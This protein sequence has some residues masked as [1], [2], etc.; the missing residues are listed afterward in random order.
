MDS[1]KIS[2]NLIRSHTPTLTTL[3]SWKV[4]RL[5][6]P[7]IHCVCV[8][9]SLFKSLILHCKTPSWTDIQGSE[10]KICRSTIWLLYYQRWHMNMLKLFSSKLQVSRGKNPQNIVF[11]LNLLYMDELNTSVKTLVRG[12]KRLR[13][14]DLAL[15]TNNKTQTCPWPFL[16]ISI[17]TSY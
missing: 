6:N 4:P 5:Y 10:P 2:H 8:S 15:Q 3:I 17:S 14:S 9:R 12:D 13:S 7:S 1:F 16:K 11:P